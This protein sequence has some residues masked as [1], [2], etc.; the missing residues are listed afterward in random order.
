VVE[1]VI[2]APS[3]STV[4]AASGGVLRDHGSDMKV[5]L[6]IDGIDAGD[7]PIGRLGFE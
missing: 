1:D 2:G 3:L 6:P 5:A 4:A 7:W